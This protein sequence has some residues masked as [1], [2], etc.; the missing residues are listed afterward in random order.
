[1]R[2]RLAQL[3]YLA[4]FVQLMLFC[5][6]CICTETIEQIK[7]DDDN[8]RYDMPSRAMTEMHP[9]DSPPPTPLSTHTEIATHIE[10]LLRSIIHAINTKDFNPSSPPWT[11]VAADYRIACPHMSS[12]LHLTNDTF[13]QTRSI[14][15]KSAWI[16]SLEDFSNHYPS[17]HI[18]IDC[19]MASVSQNSGHARAFMECRTTGGPGF[20][21]GKMSKPAM[22]MYEFRF[23]EDEG[24]W[25]FV[26]ETT[27]SGAPVCGAWMDGEKV[28]WGGG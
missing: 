16:Q 13:P 19:L 10:S 28:V 15:T 12:P 8:L 14:K 4:N 23:L 21:K 18:T 11:S 6:E 17:A 26:R 25:M 5:L 2:K 1:M 7:A 3:A 20:P 22:S 24:R 9:T 27:V